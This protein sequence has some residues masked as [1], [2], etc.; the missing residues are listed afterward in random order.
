METERFG[1][2]QRWVLALASVAA[3]MITLDALVVTTALNTIRRDLGASLSSLEWTL[4][5]YA[6]SYAAL[7][8]TGAALGD[9][10]GRRRIF[11]AGLAL[12]TA[13]SAACA[14]APGIGWLI[15]ARVVQGAGGAM[16]MPLAMSLVSTA[17][18]PR[19]RARAMG[20]FSGVMGLGV[21]GGPVVG[22]AVS[23]ALSW[24]WIFWLNV[25]LGV[26]MIPL[27]RMRVTESVGNRSRL[28]LVGVGLVTVAALAVVW[29]LVRGN[30]AGWASAGVIGSLV[31][32]VV[33]ALAFIAWER[34]VSDPM[35]PMW[36]FRDRTFAATN[37]SGFF[38]FASNFGSVFF[39]AQYFQIVFGYSPLQTGLHMLPWTTTLFV[40][41]PIAGGLVSR[42]GARI[43]VTCGL[44]LQAIGL[45]EV[46]L[47][48]DL[49]T[50]YAA[51]VPGLIVAGVGISMA[52]PATQNAVVSAVPPAAIGKASGT[53]NTLRQLGGAFGVALSVAIFSSAG[54]Y[55]GA[56][57]FTDGLV[58][59]LG[60]VA[61]LALLAAAAG[62]LMREPAPVVV[63]T[64]EPLVEA[65]H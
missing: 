23:Q 61:G 11:I 34:R 51:L 7:M 63:T 44:T 54:S 9:R 20:I 40:V 49:S 21:L 1:S 22:G 24:Q 12:F 18:G 47:A 16:I 42:W 15:A 48:A 25:P 38:L 65:A 2:A 29:G 31:A 53:F 46:A 64:A 28:D 27:V 14:L 3:V 37:F 5:A 8:M 26:L 35:L 36:L 52:M 55:G 4:N 10:L 30:T 57:A 56:A 58:P 39:I 50:S 41:A 60:G 32:G 19:Q 43:L 33:V 17:F 6:L 59:A 62:V 45:G 13:A